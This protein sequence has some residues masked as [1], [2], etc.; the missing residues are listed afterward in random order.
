MSAIEL[1]K[2]RTQIIRMIC[3]EKNEIIL[4]EVERLLTV[5][6]VSFGNTPCRYSAEEL[7]QRVRQAT[8]SI[9][10]GRGFTAEELKSLHPCLV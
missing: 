6:N 9:R 10:E 7:K 4:N 5:N 8:V 3:D 2:M 1:N